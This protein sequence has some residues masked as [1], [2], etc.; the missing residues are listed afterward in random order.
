MTKTAWLLA[1]IV[2]GLAIEL[3]VAV[4]FGAPSLSIAGAQPFTDVLPR[5]LVIGLIGLA[6]VAAVLVL[7]WR[8]RGSPDRLRAAAERAVA[9]D[10]SALRCHIK[11]VLRRA[12]GRWRGLRPVAYA[13]PWYLVLGSSQDSAS[14]LLKAMGLRLEA[15]RQAGQASGGSAGPLALV[16]SG[17]QALALSVVAPLDGLP[18][19]RDTDDLESEARWRGVLKLIR[20]TRPLQPLN[21]LI[22]ELNTSALLDATA[23]HRA[24]LAEAWRDRIAQ[25]AQIAGP[26]L[27]AYLVVTGINN[28]GGYHASCAD[29][30]EVTLLDLTGMTPA[31]TTGMR[32]KEQIRA[33]H[34]GLRAMLLRLARHS[35]R[36]AGMATQADHT[37]LILEFPVEVAIL[38]DRI[39][40]FAAAL[41]HPD[42]GRLSPVL[43]GVQLVQSPAMESHLPGDRLLRGAARSL[44]LD[45]T[46]FRPRESI[47]ARAKSFGVAARFLYRDILP[48]AGL[49]SRRHPWRT[50][51]R[52]TLAPLAALALLGASIPLG[53]VWRDKLQET[54][55]TL[56]DIEQSLAASDSAIRALDKDAGGD[57]PDLKRVLPVLDRLSANLP[58]V[59]GLG[60]GLPLAGARDV[61]LDA[62]REAY[63]RAQAQLLLPRL[64]LNLQ[65]QLPVASPQNLSPAEELALFD[66]LKTY[67]TL[68]G[69]SPGG[70]DQAR[71]WLNMHGREIAP[72]LDETTSEHLAAHV[73]AL[74]VHPLTHS[75]LDGSRIAA[76]RAALSINTLVLRGLTALQVRVRAADLPAWRLIDAAGPMAGRLLV[77]RSGKPLS[78]GVPA[79]YTRAGFLTVVAPALR[80]V[81]AALAKEGWVI[82]LAT[83]PDNRD[84]AKVLEQEI[85]EDYFTGYVD[86]WNGLMDDIAV[87]QANNLQQASQQLTQ[88]AGPASPLERLYQSASQETDL[89][90]PTTPKPASASASAPDQARAPMTGEPVTTRFAWL[91][92]LVATGDS[93]SSRLRQTIDGF[94]ALGRQMAETAYLPQDAVPT[95]SAG[96][97]AGQLADSAAG[98]P[99]PLARIASDIAHTAAS[100]TSAATE[101]RVA[102]AWREVEPFCRLV[103][104]NRY[105]FSGRASQSISLEDFASLFGP[106]GRLEKFFTTYLRPFVDTSAPAWQVHPVHGMALDIDRPALEQFQ[107]AAR[108]RDAFFTDN[109]AAPS[110]RFSL[111]PLRLD[112]AAETLTYAIGGQTLVYRHDPARLW[113]MQW[114]PADGQL[115]AQLELSPWLDNEP[116]SLDFHGPFAFLQLIEAGAPKPEGKAPDRFILR[117]TLGSRTASLRLTAASIINPFSLKDLRQFRCPEIP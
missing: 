45:V 85:A 4:W 72:E 65:T 36:R 113:P 33:L 43:R 17:R 27:P 46:Q 48:E 110:V 104:S 114:P 70:Q 49:A 32:A 16:W 18:R 75:P 14:Q 87:T 58:V 94:G 57:A 2:L 112:A 73:R 84:L 24:N 37:G 106:Q 55:Q 103:T 102:T 115:T 10:L 40:Q 69:Q 29:L 28:L 60:A 68:G 47:A 25:V 109:P 19:A 41:L 64:L 117:Y 15:E 108:I 3:A 1:I 42:C 89:T 91:R 76:A 98:L 21:G 81:A 77:R 26:F 93:G 53:L 82:P 83:G 59:A 86:A 78:E 67:L 79:F 101:D 6:A 56:T 74:M 97:S 30:D 20:R 54:R 107:R 71:A 63:D 90:P 80:E 50:A 39:T 111:E 12:N 8:R 61:L 92:D 62:H 95:P 105:P 31:G 9:A 96:S 116:G 11:T 88:L 7:L 44:A 100:M 35:V 66:R 51:W 34:D 5:I 13:S 22:L 52:A 38:T 99:A 23:D